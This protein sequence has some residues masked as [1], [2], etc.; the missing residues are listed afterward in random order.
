QGLHALWTSSS[1]TAYR[2]PCC[3]RVRPQSIFLSNNRGYW[4]G[5]WIEDG[6]D[7]SKVLGKLSKMTKSKAH[8]DLAKI[9]RPINERAAD[10][11][12]P[13]VTMKCFVEDTYF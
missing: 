13:M 7:R 11:V 2:A 8:E 3:G 5:K 6:H 4:I 1:W 10:A 9:V 12:T